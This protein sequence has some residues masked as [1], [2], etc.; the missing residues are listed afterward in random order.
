V[1]TPMLIA[2]LELIIDPLCS[3]VLE[4]ER[5]ERDVMARPPRDPASELLSRP[6]LVTGFLQGALAILAVCSVFLYATLHGLPAETVRSMGFLALVCANYALIF[7]NRSFSASPLAG[8]ARPNPSLWV[9]VA[10]AVAALAAI[11]RIPALAAFLHLGP[12]RA[13]EV[14]LCIAAAVALLGAL[15]GVKLAVRRLW[16]AAKSQA[17]LAL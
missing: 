7:A 17:E 15:E 3:V 6:L 5:D 14:L 2:I 11:F 13:G 10:A 8:F 9:S 16:A 4:A 12:L 1:L